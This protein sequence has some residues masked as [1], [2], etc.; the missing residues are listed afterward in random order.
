MWHGVRCAKAV[1]KRAWSFVKPIVVH[2]TNSLQ[3]L[4]LLRGPA[5]QHWLC[6]AQARRRVCTSLAHV[7]RF[8]PVK[9]AGSTSLGCWV[10][11]R[12]RLV[13]KPGVL[14][15]ST[16]TSYAAWISCRPRKAIQDENTAGTCFSWESTNHLFQSQGEFSMKRLRLQGSRFFMDYNGVAK[17]AVIK[18]EV[19]RNPLL[20]GCART[21]LLKRL[22]ADCPPTR[23]WILGKGGRICERHIQ[24]G[25]GLR[26]SQKK[27]PCPDHP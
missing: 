24:A 12:L 22:R 18:V 5:L 27:P 14:N 19:A 8:E 26:G 11:P 15:T 10:W 23:S 17:S 9:M 4:A 7:V 20:D 1:E 16:L 13:L 6:T 21:P 3:Q 2:F 25:A